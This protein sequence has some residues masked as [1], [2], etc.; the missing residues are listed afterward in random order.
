[1]VPVCEF[2][3]NLTRHV[4]SKV[5][6]VQIEALFFFQKKKRIKSITWPEMPI[7]QQG[8]TKISFQTLWHLLMPGNLTK[9]KECNWDV[10]SEILNSTSSFGDD[11]SLYV[12]AGKEN[13]CSYMGSMCD[14]NNQDSKLQH[15]S[16]CQ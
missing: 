1:M 14:N 4:E 6:E 5:V 13:Y 9:V 16:T 15:I 10:Q 7:Q 8:A 3:G 2:E 12:Y 11:S